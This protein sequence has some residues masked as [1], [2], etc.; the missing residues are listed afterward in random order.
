MAPTQIN[1]HGSITSVI[2]R[3]GLQQT[4]TMF[5]RDKD[6]VQC[7]SKRIHNT[8]VGFRKICTAG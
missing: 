6:I 3:C 1:K 2:G 7:H 5:N 8:S 4:L